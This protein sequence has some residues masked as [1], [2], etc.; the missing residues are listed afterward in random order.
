MNL[1]LYMCVGEGW[2]YGCMSAYMQLKVKKTASD[3]ALRS[4][5]DLL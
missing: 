4:T 2:A 5:I 3:A 1:T